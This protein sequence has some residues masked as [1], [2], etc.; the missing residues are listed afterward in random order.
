[1]LDFQPYEVTF[2]DSIATGWHTFST[3]DPQQ[4]DHS[5][6][7]TSDIHDEADKLENL[8]RLAI[9]TATTS[10]NL[11]QRAIASPCWS[12]DINRPPGWSCTRAVSG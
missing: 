5:I 3:I 11:G 7:I 4:K 9:R 8:L 12:K 6:F 2:G 1:M 10:T